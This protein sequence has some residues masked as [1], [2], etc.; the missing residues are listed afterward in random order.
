M[1][2]A[3]SIGKGGPISI[4]YVAKTDG[5]SEQ[6]EL[7]FNVAYI[8]DLTGREDERMLESRDPISVNKHNRKTVLESLAP[9]M[10][11]EVENKLGGEDPLGVQL[12]IKHDD[13]W[14]PEGVAKQIPELQKLLQL[15][16]ALEAVKAPLAGVTARPFKKAL[17]AILGDEEKAEQL[18]AALFTSDEDNSGTSAGDQAEEPPDETPGG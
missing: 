7:P 8:G 6:R 13:D 15:R 1:D 4:T 17:E 16:A 14:T 10:V 3:Q 5:A 2:D 9:S 11:I 18:R 12:T